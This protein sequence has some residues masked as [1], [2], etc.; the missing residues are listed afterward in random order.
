MPWMDLSDAILDPQFIDSLQVARNK[1]VVGEDGVAQILPVTKNFYGIVVIADG[2][3]LI[4]LADGE[5]ITT[6][7]EVI[8]T[9]KLI[10]GKMG[11]TADV[12]SW[13]DQQWTVD[14]VSP[15]SKYGKGFCLALCTMKTL[16]G[17]DI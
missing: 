1:E 15:Y 2:S 4:R 5:H 13:H 9:E 14:H 12:I 8:T 3:V 17:G 6:T 16:Q 10:D 7:I 11:F